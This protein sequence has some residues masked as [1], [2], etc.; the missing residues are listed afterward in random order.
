MPDVRT[1]DV[2]ISLLSGEQLPAMLALPERTPAPAVLVIN[3]VFGRS[4]FYDH[5]TRRIAQAGFVALD[6]EYFFREGP[7][8][9]DDRAAATDRREKLVQRRVLDDLDTAFAWLAARGDVGGDRFGTIGFCMGGTF[10]LDL[11]ASRGDLATVSYYGFPAARRPDMSP[12]L[13]VAARMTGPILGHFGTEDTGV[14]MDNVRELD[15]RLTAAGVEHELHTYEGLGHGF[16]K[17]FLENESAPGYE[18]ACTSWKRTLDFWRRHLSRELSG[19]EA[20][21]A[22]RDDGW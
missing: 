12:P 6:P 2:R 13:D 19:S 20:W 22:Q 14:G 5:L 11:A 15:R 4:D 21:E 9:Q 1:E 18:Q 17:T 16:L 10:A 3:D 7:V 8:P